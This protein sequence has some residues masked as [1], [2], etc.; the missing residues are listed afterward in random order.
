VCLN[1]LISYYKG[2]NDIKII[3]FMAIKGGVG[4]TIM[5]YQ[6]AKYIQIKKKNGVGVADL[7]IPPM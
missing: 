5:A 4:K 7:I 1:I 2:N 6:L 3:I